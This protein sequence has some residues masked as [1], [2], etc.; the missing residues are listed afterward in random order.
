M[1]CHPVYQ[2]INL[3]S[4]LLPLYVHASII[5]FGVLFLIRLQFSV[6]ICSMVRCRRFCHTPTNP[7]FVAP[8]SLQVTRTTWPSG[9]VWQNTTGTTSEQLFRTKA[10]TASW[11]TTP[12]TWGW[13]ASRDPRGGGQMW[14]DGNAAETKDKRSEG[15]RRGENREVSP[16]R[17]CDTHPA[18]NRWGSRKHEL[19]DR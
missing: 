2:S 10:S 1:S 3:P 18:D 9:A 5:V 7:P 12:R 4:F 11:R 13:S 15:G 19:L 8:P 16:K 6:S 17:G 14:C